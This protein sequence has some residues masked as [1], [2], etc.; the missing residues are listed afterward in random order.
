MLE[1]LRQ[2]QKEKEETEEQRKL[3]SS[4]LSEEELTKKMNDKIKE[5]QDRIKELEEKQKKNIE[6]LDG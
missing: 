6:I 4:N 2:L 1:Q 3:L 5:Q